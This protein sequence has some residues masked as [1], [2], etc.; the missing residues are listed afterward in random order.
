M[1]KGSAGKKKKKG[2][3][4]ASANKKGEGRAFLDPQILRF[5]HA[6]ISRTF[7]GCGRGVLDTLEDIKQGKLAASD[8][9][10]ITVVDLGDTMDEDGN[11]TRLLV[12][13][14]NRR[15]F[16]LKQCRDLGL[17]ENNTIEVRLRPPPD[18]KKQREKF[19]PERCKLVARFMSPRA[20]K[21]K[22]D[23]LEEQGLSVGQ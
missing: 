21:V 20:P 7:S 8:L 5:E 4:G 19:T 1:G 22:T 18:S 6:R 23:E 16:V 17:L 12:S 11:P 10:K 15:L 14:N 3:G 9:P 2:D 13:L